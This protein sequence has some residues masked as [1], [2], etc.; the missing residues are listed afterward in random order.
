MQTKVE[1]VYIALKADV[2]FDGKA[3]EA[4]HR[5][6]EQHQADCGPNLSWHLH[7]QHGRARAH[8]NHCQLLP[9]EDRRAN[10]LE[11]LF[12]RNGF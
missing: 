7:F 12:G 1:N 11:H 9:G 10:G 8:G 3:G 6:Q 5:T 4:H 2:Y